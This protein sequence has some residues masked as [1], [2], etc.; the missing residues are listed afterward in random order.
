MFALQ[1]FDRQGLEDFDPCPSRSTRGVKYFLV[2]FRCLFRGNEQ[3]FVVLTQSEINQSQPD[4][5]FDIAGFE[6]LSPTHQYMIWQMV[7]LNLREAS[8]GILNLYIFFK[9]CMLY[10]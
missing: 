1:V 9:A 8:I 5:I 2:C 6:S 3:G 10:R 7:P 4:F